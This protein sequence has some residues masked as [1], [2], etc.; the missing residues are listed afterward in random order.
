MLADAPSGVGHPNLQPPALPPLS[1]VL[2]RKAG[3][4]PPLSLVTFHPVDE[5]SVKKIDSVSPVPP[6]MTN[7]AVLP[8]VESTPSAA[9]PVRP[10][11]LDTLNTLD[12]RT[13]S[14]RSPQPNQIPPPTRKVRF[15]FSSSSSYVTSPPYCSGVANCVLAIVRCGA[16]WPSPCM[17]GGG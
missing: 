11:T 3:P 16:S 8:V 6:S 17:R 2:P 10:N 14:R 7:D 9:A 15:P 5:T 13:C 4:R 1:F 12:P